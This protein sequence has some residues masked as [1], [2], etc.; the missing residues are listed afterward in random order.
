MADTAHHTWREALLSYAQ[1]RV[2]AI[3]FLGFAAGLPY[4]LVFSTLSAWLTE[5]DVGRATIGFF[6]WVGITFSIKVVWA[7]WWIVCRFRV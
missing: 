4:L 7:P 3:L 5:A 1:P 2:V 6:S